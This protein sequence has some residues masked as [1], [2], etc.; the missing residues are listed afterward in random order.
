MDH[1]KRPQDK[2]RRGGNGCVKPFEKAESKGSQ[3]GTPRACRVG[4]SR[5]VCSYSV[6]TRPKHLSAEPT[7]PMVFLIANFNTSVP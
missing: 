6:G 3:S 1:S 7:S 5:G 4:S 2:P